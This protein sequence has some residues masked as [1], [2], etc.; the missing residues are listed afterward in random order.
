M[1][2]IIEFDSADEMKAA[3]D[4]LAGKSEV[5]KPGVEIENGMGQTLALRAGPGDEGRVRVQVLPRTK[6]TDEFRQ[7]VPGVLALAPGDRTE[8]T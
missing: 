1:R 2:H 8:V 7:P 4:V 5:E 3:L 6:A